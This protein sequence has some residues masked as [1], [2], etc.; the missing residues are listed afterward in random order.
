M[1]IDISKYLLA[2]TITGNP[3]ISLAVSSLGGSPAGIALLAVAAGQRRTGAPAV[4]TAAAPATTAAPQIVPLPRRVQ[5]PEV[6][7]DQD[8][9]V[10]VLQNHGLVGTIEQV[11]SDEPI[12]N[13]IGT[14]PEAGTLVRMGSTVTV[15]VSAGARVPNVTGQE[16]EEAE[17]ALRASGF[18][19][20]DTQISKTQTG[21][22]GVVADQDPKG[23]TYADAESAVTLILFRP[24]RRLEAADDDG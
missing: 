22:E 9:A 4:P 21:R 23:G 14:D 11:A 19:V 3:T 8:E 20:G 13:V 6:P 5:V 10:Q 1:A 2:Y 18:T 16:L 24:R 7:D 17:K 12:D 15:L